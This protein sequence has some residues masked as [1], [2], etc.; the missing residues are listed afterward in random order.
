M[1]NNPY[2]IALEH[3]K[4]PIIDNPPFPYYTPL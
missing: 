3:F 1:T 4:R 2:D